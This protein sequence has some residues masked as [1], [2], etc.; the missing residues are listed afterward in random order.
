MPSYKEKGI[1]MKKSIAATV[2]LALLLTVTMPASAYGAISA[3]DA[4]YLAGLVAKGGYRANDR[5]VVMPG[6]NGRIDAVQM[7]A[8]GGPIEDIEAFDDQLQA[9]QDQVWDDVIIM[10]P[11]SV[12]EAYEG[13]ADCASG[14]ACL[15]EHKRFGGRMLMFQS[16]GYWQSLGDYGFRNKTSSWVNKRNHCSYLD[17]Y[18]WAGSSRDVYMSGNARARTMDANNMADAIYNSYDDACKN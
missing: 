13:A 8:D 12:M 18:E 17:V 7:P 4:E 1:K 11:P 5:T 2:M 15:F 10:V 6:A 9:Q 3:L 16:V 14:W